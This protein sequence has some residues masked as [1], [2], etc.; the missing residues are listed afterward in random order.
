MPAAMIVPAQKRLNLRVIGKV[1]SHSG[2]LILNGK[3]DT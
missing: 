3:N 1:P 2:V